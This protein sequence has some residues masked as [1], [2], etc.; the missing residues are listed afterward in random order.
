MCWSF[1]LIVPI[2]FAP[3][4]KTDHLALWFITIFSMSMATGSIIGTSTKT[5]NSESLDNSQIYINHQF[6]FYSL[7]LLSFISFIGLYLLFRYASNVYSFNNYVNNWMMIP[8][9]IA[10]DRYAGVLDYPILIKYSLYFY[11]FISMS[12]TRK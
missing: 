4:Y 9:M 10:V 8:N 6:L 2:V 7:I 5:I 3:D 11:S 12:C 1:F